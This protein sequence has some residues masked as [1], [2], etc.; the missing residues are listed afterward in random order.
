MNRKQ[1]LTATGLFYQS[2]KQVIYVRQ[3][4]ITANRIF[5]L[6]P[7]LLLGLLNSA[8]SKILSKNKT[9]HEELYNQM[10]SY[11]PWSKL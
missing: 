2:Q 5:P 11:S 4:L 9:I 8:A 10:H 3:P 6:Y 7:G 1:H